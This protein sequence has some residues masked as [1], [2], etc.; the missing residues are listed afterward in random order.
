MRSQ[1]TESHCLG[2][3]MLLVGLSGSG[4]KIAALQWPQKET[5]RCHHV[6]WAVNL[7]AIL[8]DVYRFHKDVIT[9]EIALMV[10]TRTSVI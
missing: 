8:E 7:L 1:M 2:I 9:L 10:R 3:K 4:M 5:S 6:I